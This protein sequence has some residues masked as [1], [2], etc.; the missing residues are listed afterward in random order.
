MLQIEGLTVS[1]ERMRIL[2]DVRIELAAGKTVGL[3][4]RNGAGKTTLMRAIMGLLPVQSGSILLGGIDLIRL[5]AHQRAALA[6]GYMPED[7]RLVP[8]FTI[9]AN[10]LLPMWATGRKSEPQRLAWIYELMPEIGRHPDRLALTLSG[11]QQK[12]VALG[13]ALMCGSKVLLL[14]EPFEGVAPALAGRLVQVIA[15][16]QREGIAVLISESDYTHS[17]DILNQLYVI[18]RGIVEERVPEAADRE[19]MKNKMAELEE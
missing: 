19:T 4:G 11:G 8:G 15:K 1:I 16:L 2:S 10:I 18:E 12:L 5:A 14:D 6:V 7:R 13:R 17:G 9:E 3:I